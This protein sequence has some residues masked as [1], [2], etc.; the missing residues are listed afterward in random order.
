MRKTWIPPIIPMAIVHLLAHTVR[1]STLY[2]ILCNLTYITDARPS[3]SKSSHK[4][5][6]DSKS[7]RFYTL[8]ADTYAVADSPLPSD[9]EDEDEYGMSSI[10]IPPRPILTPPRPI[11]DLPRSPRPKRIRRRGPMTPSRSVS[12]DQ[13]D[14][15]R[16]RSDEPSQEQ[17]QD[18]VSAEEWPDVLDELKKGSAKLLPVSILTSNP[19]VIKRAHPSGYGHYAFHLSKLLPPTSS[20]DALRAYNDNYDEIGKTS[21]LAVTRQLPLIQSRVGKIADQ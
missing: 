6:R 7:Q 5:P 16:Q 20:K 9:E 17:P 10:L 14:S 2:L 15:D 4:R 3:Q 19:T 12:R 21:C 8:F 13:D 11:V 1:R 18:R